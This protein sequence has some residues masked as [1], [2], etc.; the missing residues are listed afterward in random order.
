VAA[1]DALSSETFDVAL[2]DAVLVG[3][4]GL[5]LVR[6]IRMGETGDPDI[7]IGVL[8]WPGNDAM[9]ARA[10]GLDAD[11]VMMRPF[12]LVALSASVKRLARRTWNAR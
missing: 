9:V 10:Y 6:R 2:I 5:D 1:L 4:D 3:V 12:S 7:G 8:C 11:D